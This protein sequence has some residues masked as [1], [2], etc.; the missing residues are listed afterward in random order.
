MLEIIWFIL[1]QLY[2]SFGYLR[3]QYTGDHFHLY[4]IRR[5][6]LEKHEYIDSFL[7]KKFSYYRHLSPDGRNKFQARLCKVLKEVEFV[8]QHGLEITEDMKLSVLFAKVQLTYGLN[9]FHFKRFKRFV[10]YPETFYS[11]YFDRDLKG[12]TSAK[13]FVLLSWYDFEHGYQVDNDNYNLGLHEMAHVLRLMLRL[14]PDIGT[15]IHQLNRKM[16]SIS[17]EER[18]LAARGVPSIL[19]DYAYTN[20]EEFFA[21]CVEYFFEAPQLLKEHKPEIYYIL[22]KM[23][24]Q[25]PLNHRSDYRVDNEMQRIIYDRHKPQMKRNMTGR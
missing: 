21:V 22:G 8:G 17:L 12:L 23:L 20:E 11:R 9:F 14:T 25:D 3:F 19:R 6:S 16:S 10:L 13:G 5:F 24:N 7:D 2:R 1:K 15:L 18:E 4:S